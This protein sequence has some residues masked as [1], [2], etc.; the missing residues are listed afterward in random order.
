M[1]GELA[2]DEA[3]PHEGRRALAARAGVGMAGQQ[4]KG[5]ILMESQEG[6]CPPGGGSKGSG[7]YG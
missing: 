1:L 4:R 7:Q 5:L 2:L 3:A 6:Q